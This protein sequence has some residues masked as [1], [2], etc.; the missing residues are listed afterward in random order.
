MRKKRIQNGRAQ[1]SSREKLDKINKYQVNVSTDDEKDEMNAKKLANPEEFHRASR[2]ISHQF[3]LLRRQ[4][5]ASILKQISSSANNN[6]KER[7]QEVA[8][9]L[10]DK[11][12]IEVDRKIL[13]ECG[14]DLEQA[15]VMLQMAR[16]PLL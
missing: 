1:R 4:A 9:L 16:E 15:Q 6:N 2:T 5:N 13:T 8:K 14:D 11:K 7:M 10:S 12:F 3:D